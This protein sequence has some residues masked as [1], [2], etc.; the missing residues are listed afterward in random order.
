MAFTTLL[1]TDTLAS[2]LADPAMVIVDCRY[3]LDDESW[4]TR[5]YRTRHIPGAGYAHLGHDL[6]G[7]RTGA[8][9]RHPLPDAGALRETFSRLGITSGVQVVAYDQ[10]SGMYASRFWWLLRW[11]GHDAAA[12]LDGGFA[13]WIA[14]ARSTAA[15]DERRDR[16]E[17]RGAPRDG[18]T[19]NADEVGAKID[20][21]GWRIVDARAPER[22]RGETEPL[23]KVAGHIPSAANHF[24]KWNLNEAGVFRSPADLRRTLGE[25]MGDV[26]PERVICYCG[27]G[28]T[29][30]HNLLALEHAGL[31]GA[32]L[33]PGSWSEW[34]SDPSRPMAR[35]TD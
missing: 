32:K 6:A 12:V 21:P 9:G 14:E 22:Y 13:K 29:A 25:A 4:G 7:A 5:E 35:K 11:L 18:W 1:T 30:C 26:P 27:S 8:N 10:D 16:R 17:F 34:S 31:H 15:G 33:Y 20:T 2:R 23:D 3:N 28:V 24:F 19:V